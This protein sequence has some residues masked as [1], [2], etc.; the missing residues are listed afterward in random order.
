MYAA[1]A[2]IDFFKH[3][4]VNGYPHIAREKADETGWHD[5]P[6]YAEF[7]SLKQKINQMARFAFAYLSSYYPMLESINNSGGEYRAPWYINLFERKGVDL[8]SAMEKELKQLKSYCESFLLWLANIEQSQ[9]GE[10]VTGSGQLINYNA[11]A[12]TELDENGKQVV[13]LKA[14]ALFKREEF[15]NLLLPI[16]KEYPRALSDLW[17]MMSDAHVKDTNADGIGRFVHALYRECGEVKA[18]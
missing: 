7:A 9:T 4:N 17:R 16:T 15:A 18:E 12:G 8:K 11:F 6:Y 13:R 14:P 5:L 3:D 10:N 1:L 2:A